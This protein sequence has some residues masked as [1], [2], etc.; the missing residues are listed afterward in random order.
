MTFGDRDQIASLTQRERETLQ[1]LVDGLINKLI[2]CQPRLSVHGAKRLVAGI[3]A[4]LNCPNRTKAA[5]I[6]VREQAVPL[7]RT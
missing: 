1:L 4:K 7:S 3:V 6:D 5:T 2:A